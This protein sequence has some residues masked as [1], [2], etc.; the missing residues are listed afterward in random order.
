[1]I[2]F[3][4]NSILWRS[5]VSPFWR[6]CSKP[7]LLVR[8]VQKEV[9]D[10]LNILKNNH[11]DVLACIKRLMI[12][13]HADTTENKATYESVLSRARQLSEVSN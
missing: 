7:R 9:N 13:F 4:I 1:M 2:E 11:D 8:D 12:K 5:F 6:N 10:V 3:G